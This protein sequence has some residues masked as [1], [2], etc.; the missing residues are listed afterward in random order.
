M[1]GRAPDLLIRQADAMA[2]FSARRRWLRG[3][4]GGAGALAL[5]GCDRLSQDDRVL[6]GSRAGVIRLVGS[7]QPRCRV[8]VIR[9]FG[10]HHRR[11]DGG[12]SLRHR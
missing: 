12:N 5:A 8:G 3:L 1:S 6:V 2:R 10:R 9:R 11:S 4:V 7:T